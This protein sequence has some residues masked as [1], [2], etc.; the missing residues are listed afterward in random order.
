M[1]HNKMQPKL[2]LSCQYGLP[3][4]RPAA[5]ERFRVSKALANPATFTFLYI[6][7]IIPS[8]PDLP[9]IYAAEITASAILRKPYQIQFFTVITFLFEDMSTHTAYD[10]R[11]HVLPQK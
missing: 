2:L 10:C 8:L 5:K 4:E 11:K 1:F 9:K 3:E 7:N 6:Y